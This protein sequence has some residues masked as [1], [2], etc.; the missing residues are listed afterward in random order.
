MSK[1]VTEFF[2]KNS[3][4]VITP[5][6]INS[7]FNELKAKRIRVD[8]SVENEKPHPWTQVIFLNF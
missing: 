8:T 5:E 6:D 3:D 2:E 7:C 4:K 1:H